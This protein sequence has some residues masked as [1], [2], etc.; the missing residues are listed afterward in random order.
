MVP[1][2]KDAVFK[3]LKGQTSVEEIIRAVNED[4]VSE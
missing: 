3:L 2:R 1:L 4:E